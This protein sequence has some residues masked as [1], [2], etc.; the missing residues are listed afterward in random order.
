MLIL[1]IRSTNK[2]Y[3][4]NILTVKVKIIRNIDKLPV[5]VNPV[6]TIGSFDG[7]HCGHK[8]I[9]ERIITIAK[10]INGNSVAITFSPHPQAVLCN[11]KKKLYI[12][13][14]TEEK[15][16]LFEPLGIDYLIIIPFTKEF[17]KIPYDKFIKDYLVDKIKVA[18]LVI[19]Y[20]HHFGNN[21]EGSISHLKYLSEKYSFNIEEVSAQ[22]INEEAVS[23]TKIR[24]ALLA[25]E[26]AKANKYLG[27]FY[28][29]TG[30]VVKGNGLGR[31]LNF[32]T[33][34]IEVNETDKLIPA[35][36]VYAVKVIVD[37]TVY[38]GML[39]TGIRP[40]IGGTKRVNEV[41]IFNFSGEI[42]NSNITILFMERLRN[43]IY[44]PDIN[45]LKEQ[46]ILDKEAA[47][48]I[49]L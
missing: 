11:H 4:E 9:I 33:A 5:F 31:T 20:D 19:G 12:I 10:K 43:E 28:S 25:G 42:Y 49:L 8:A 37:N 48:K 14:T 26:I 34:N 15:I 18:T 1:K 47:L 39:N 36:G 29:I 3:I 2:F 17:S 21:R 35:D 40:T 32:P 22:Y 16:K 30:K 44:F 46:L 38:N 13:N 7:V 24:N 45:K 41:N 23:S 27:Y 6:V